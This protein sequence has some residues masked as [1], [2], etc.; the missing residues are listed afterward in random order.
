M[1]EYNDK[2]IKAFTCIGTAGTTKHGINDA[3]SAAMMEYAVA[4]QLL[5][6]AEKRAKD[7][8]AKAVDALGPRMHDG[9]GK[10]E[11]Y[12]DDRVTIVLDNRDAPFL[13][14]QAALLNALCKKLNMP[15]GDAQAF[16]EECKTQRSP[17]IQYWTTVI[18]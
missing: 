14:D 17:F 7:A 9:K 12:S 11:V 18:K 15:V 3:T 5:S 13:L 4:K 16:I 8:K 10:A 1:S 2:L 6:M